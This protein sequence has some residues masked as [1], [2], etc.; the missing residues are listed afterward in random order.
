MTTFDSA[1]AHRISDHY[2]VK[3]DRGHL[4]GQYIM[5]ANVHMVGT[6]IRSNPAG[7]TIGSCTSS[8]S[9]GSKGTKATRDTHIVSTQKVRGYLS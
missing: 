9:V 5:I 1:S 7:R 8:W 6:W 4:H 3:D 2:R